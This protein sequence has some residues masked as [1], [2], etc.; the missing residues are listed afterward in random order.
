MFYNMIQVH[1]QI[2]KHMEGKMYTCISRPVKPVKAGDNGV[3][4]RPVHKREKGV[5][6]PFTV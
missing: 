1:I 4:G 2:H 5:R 6:G 3:R